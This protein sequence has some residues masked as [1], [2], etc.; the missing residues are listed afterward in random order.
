VLVRM[1]PGDCPAPLCGCKMAQT[2]ENSRFLQ[3]WNMELPHDPKTQLLV[4]MQEKQKFL[5]AK[6]SCTHMLISHQY[7]DTVM[8]QHIS[9]LPDPG[10]WEEAGWGGALWC[11]APPCGTRHPEVTAADWEKQSQGQ[12]RMCCTGICF[13]R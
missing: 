1:G 3:R 10:F 2:L 7:W 5:S 8:V 11:L 13:L 4:Y 9:H 12:E 6:Q